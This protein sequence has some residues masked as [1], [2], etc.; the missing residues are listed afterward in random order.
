MTR[1]NT[2][3]GA[4]VAL[5]ISAI[6]MTMALI[7]GHSAASRVPPDLSAPEAGVD[8][9]RALAL[10]AREPG[11]VAIVDVRPA[12]A[13]ALYHLPQ[14]QNL[15][16]ASVEKL[17]GATMGRKGLLLVADSDTQAAR[18]AAL[19]RA[20]KLPATIHFLKEGVRELYLTLE[21]P[22]PLFADKPPPH[23]YSQALATV[24][25][26][27][28]APGQAPSP[29]VERAIGTLAS[30]GYQPSLLSG[31]KKPAA[32]GAKRKIAGGC[33]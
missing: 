9:Y 18:L 17:A 20:R 21:L 19:L 5:A 25:A 33:G 13:F 7:S 4:I 29:E 15:P 27:L 6:Y 10:L 2:L 22:V 30:V 23:G 16:D 12:N 11:Q 32:G 3:V 26:W 24:K 1:F 31:K 28:R 14:A 8:V